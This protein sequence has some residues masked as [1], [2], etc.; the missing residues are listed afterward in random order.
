MENELTVTQ[1]TQQI[2]KIQLNG[3]NCTVTT[4]GQ[5]VLPCSHIGNGFC[6][7]GNC[8]YE[9]TVELKIC[10]S[11]TLNTNNKSFNLEKSCISKHSSALQYNNFNVELPTQQ[12][13][14]TI[15]PNFFNYK[16]RLFEYED[17]I[18][19]TYPTICSEHV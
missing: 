16:K 10:N 9:K 12:I 13:V 1:Q 15:K 11:N 8:L 19:V 17:H 3:Q 5:C 2:P 6:S 14:R 7:V 4:M 18:Y